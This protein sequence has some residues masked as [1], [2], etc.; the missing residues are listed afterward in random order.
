VILTSQADDDFIVEALRMGASGYVLKQ[1]GGD[2]LIRAV[3]AAARGETALD[4]Q[5]AARVVARMRDL[6]TQVEA[7]AF[8]DL[9]PR[10]KDVLRLVAQGQSNKEIGAA[11]NLSDITVRN[12]ISNMLDKLE[13][14]NRVELAAF[15]TA[16]HLS[17]KS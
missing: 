5:T 11:L 2:E 13:L 16:H 9:S 12:Y 10:E 14:S 7:S 3:Q 6:E 1:V 15:A 17:D 8:K 4:P